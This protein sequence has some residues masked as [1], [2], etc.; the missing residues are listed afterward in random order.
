MRLRF[1]PLYRA[2]LVRLG[3]NKSPP[4]EEEIMLSFVPDITP[5]TPVEELLEPEPEIPNMATI[6]PYEIK[7]RKEQ[8]SR[9]IGIL[10][11]PHADVQLRQ[12]A[13]RQLRSLKKITKKSW[14]SLGVKPDHTLIIDLLLEEE[15][16]KPKPSR[17]VQALSARLK[18]Q[19]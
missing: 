11:N 15:D 3:V 16:S 4:L 14:A 2:L 12:Q 17:K 10:E 13:A 1:L 8:A 6:P 9:H 7:S 19:A 18:G 5:E